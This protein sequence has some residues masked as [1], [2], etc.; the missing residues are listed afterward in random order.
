MAE[1]KVTKEEVPQEEEKDPSQKQYFISF[2][3]YN[4]FVNKAIY[5]IV[6][7]DLQESNLTDVAKKLI[8]EKS[9]DVDLENI[10]IK[11]NSFNNI[12]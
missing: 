10:T 9:P 2:D 7:C 4:K 5:S 8:A 12:D 3:Y 11:I 6:T 1:E